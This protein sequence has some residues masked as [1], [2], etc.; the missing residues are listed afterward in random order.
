[1]SDITPLAYPPTAILT[2]K[3]VAEW[4]Q[5]SERTVRDLPVPR[6]PLPKPRYS[7]GAVLRYL[8]GSA[9]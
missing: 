5:I 9:A 8:E 2:Q 1:M 3:Q 4:L 6:L 7:A